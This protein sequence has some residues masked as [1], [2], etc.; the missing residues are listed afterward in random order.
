[1]A[2]L[3]PLKIFDPPAPML[4]IYLENSMGG[5]IKFFTH[6][7]NYELRTIIDPD[8]VRYLNH[9]IIPCLSIITYYD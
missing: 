5:Y 3:P 8:K 9:R 6:I 1:M 4:E 7:S 2:S